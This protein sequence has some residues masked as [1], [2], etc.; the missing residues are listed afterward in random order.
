M[1]PAETLSGPITNGFH[2]PFSSGHTLCY[3]LD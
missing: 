2:Q 1:R 3:M